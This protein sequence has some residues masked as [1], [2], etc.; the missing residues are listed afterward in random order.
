M[1]HIKTSATPRVGAAPASTGL[2]ACVALACRG[3]IPG[4][5]VDNHCCV[6]PVSAL[7][8]RP[9]LLFVEEAT[10]PC[11]ITGL[12]LGLGA[13]PHALAFAK[14]LRLCEVFVFERAVGFAPRYGTDL[15]ACR[16]EIGLGG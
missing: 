1:I 11:P 14:A 8:A 5:L 3:G 16:A 13:Q 9:D 12:V 10:R 2:G 7:R 4:G 6:A 15:V